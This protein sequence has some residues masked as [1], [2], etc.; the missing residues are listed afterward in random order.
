MTTP[1]SST[2]REHLDKKV[3]SGEVPNGVDT[4]AEANMAKAMD[5]YGTR[6]VDLAFSVSVQRKADI[7][8][9]SQVAVATHAAL[10]PPKKG[11]DWPGWLAG[12]SLGV[13]ANTIPGFFPANDI[14]GETLALAVGS[15]AGTGLLACLA[16]WRAFK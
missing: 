13:F 5:D 10:D 15:L 3:A 11:V 8:G 14:S 9:V 4:T 12:F 7:V 6:L 2:V 1:F 16:M